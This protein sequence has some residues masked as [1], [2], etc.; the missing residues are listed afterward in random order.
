MKELSE[1]ARLLLARYKAVESLTP[2]HEERLLASLENA[3]ARGAQPRFD[4]AGD[5]GPLVA[6]VP[7]RVSRRG[8]VMRLSVAIV[9]LTAVPALAIVGF[10]AALIPTPELA[11]TIIEAPTPSFSEATVPEDIEMWVPPPAPVA[12]KAA[13]PSK[14]GASLR[15]GRLRTAD[16]TI[17][18]EMRLLK[19]AQ[20][21]GAG[22]E[23][24]RALQLLDEYGLRFPQGRLG[25]LRDVVRL[26]ALC[27]LGQTDKLRQEADRFFVRYPDSPYTQRVK[28][29]CAGSPRP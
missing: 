7:P 8:W 3:L 18:G 11:P 13:R 26:T 22:G 6:P 10:K 9:A 14:S 17:D 29:I 19:E 21:A 27:E 4:Q 12:T 25:D 2:A 20:A 15:S 5:A 24:R 23:W 16:G 1:N 28:G